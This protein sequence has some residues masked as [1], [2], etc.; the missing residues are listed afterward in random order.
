MLGLGWYVLGPKLDIPFPTLQGVGG[1][2]DSVPEITQNTTF[3]SV[4]IYRVVLTGGPCGGKTS[5]MTHF[6]KTLK[7]KGYSVYVIPEIPTL[8]FNAGTPPISAMSDGQLVTL[9]KQILN[10]Q[11]RF[12]N[13]VLSVAQ[14][15]Q[16]PAV[17]L[18][19]RGILDVAAYLPMATWQKIID[20][21]KWAEKD[22]RNRYDLV[23]HLVTAAKG[24]EQF[25][26]TENN[27]IR[28]EGLA[29]V[30]VALIISLVSLWSLSQRMFW[31]LD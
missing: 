4:P 11:L 28:T 25:Y 14:S 7:A 21:N 12:E 13:S 27:A 26:T 18:Y 1:R 9:E 15:M 8:L 10:L 2:K 17:I 20:S 30:N 23:V 29:Q 16:K 3:G 24:A 6:E 22:L 19:D 31:V 5:A